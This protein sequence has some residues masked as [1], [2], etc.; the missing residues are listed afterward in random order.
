[1]SPSGGRFAFTVSAADGGGNTAIVREVPT[2]CAP[3]WDMALVPDV[4]SFEWLG[5][6]H[7]VFSRADETGRPYQVIYMYAC[8]VSIIQRV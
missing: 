6:R 3:V 2:G 7:I 1:V 5:E 4:E 8:T